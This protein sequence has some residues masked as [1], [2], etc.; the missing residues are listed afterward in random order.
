M[1]GLTGVEL[2]SSHRTVPASSAFFKSQ[3]ASSRAPSGFS[4]YSRAAVPRAQPG[5]LPPKPPRSARVGTPGLA[6][7]D[8]RHIR[9]KPQPLR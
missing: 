5:T 7:I 3:R 9:Q 4:T 1:V 2:S 8:L 6:G